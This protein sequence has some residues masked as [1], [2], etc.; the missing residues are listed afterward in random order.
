MEESDLIYTE[1]ALCV[2]ER[3]PPFPGHDEIRSV[4]PITLSGR[5]DVGG[6]GCVRID[7]KKFIN[8]DKI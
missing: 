7:S 6:E 3:I 4:I 5:S 8:N 1:G 2:C